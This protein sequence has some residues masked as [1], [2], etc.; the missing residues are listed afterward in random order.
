MLQLLPCDWLCSGS[1]S[2]QPPFEGA[3]EVS[4]AEFMYYGRWSDRRAR[5]DT[6]KD[7]IGTSLNRPAPV[8]KQL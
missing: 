5:A 2:L 8:E 6:I 4:V 3:G 7:S 1:L